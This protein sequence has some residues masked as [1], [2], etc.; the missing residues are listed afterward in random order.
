MTLHTDT[1]QLLV[2]D[3]Q[4]KLFAAMPEARRADTEKAVGVLGRMAEVLKLPVVLTEQYP[5]GI[6]PSIPAVQ[7]SFADLPKHEKL[8][9]SAW[10]CEAARTELE[11]NG[12]R[13]VL[14]VGQECHICV[15]QSVRDLLSHG[16]EVHVVSEGVLSRIDENRAIGLALMEKLGAVTTSVEVALFDLL[17][18]AGGDDF[19]VLSK[20]IR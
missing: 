13:Q 6:G 11:K 9:F 5:K 15:Y 3:I 14:V 2:I 7:E 4:E 8:I 10:G 18:E 17:K 19:K 1:T 16:F 20:L 12:R